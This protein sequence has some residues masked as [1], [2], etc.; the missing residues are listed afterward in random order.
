MKKDE[1]FKTT[2]LFANPKYHY[3]MRPQSRGLPG[4]GRLNTSVARTSGRL[5]TSSGVGVGMLTEL[6]V[7]QRPLTQMGVRVVNREQGRVGRQVYDKT[8]YLT[9]LRQRLGNLREAVGKFNAE[10]LEIQNDNN[11]HIKKCKF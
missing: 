10:L 2:K 8:Y 3:Q 11:V 4:G 9:E 7:T 6:S 1:F 5:G